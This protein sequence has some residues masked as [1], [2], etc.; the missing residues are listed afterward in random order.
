MN[1]P[2]SEQIEEGDDI[3]NMPLRNLTASTLL[4]A[5]ATLVSAQPAAAESPKPALAIAFAGYD[6]FI[7]D[8]KTLDEISG[9]TKLASLAESNIDLATQSKGLEGLD[10]ARPWGV[11]VAL[12]DDGQPIVQGFLPVTDL[13]KLVASIP[14]PGG[15][16]PD[17]NDKGVYEY[18]LG[19][20]SMFVKQKG[21]WAV[22]SDSEEN[23][24]SASE[25]AVSEFSELPKKYLLSVRG[26][27]KNVPEAA[28]DKALA[29]LRGFVELTLS[30]QPSGS[31]EQRALLNANVKQMFEKLEILGKEL[32]SLVI[33]VGLD[34]ESKSLFLDFESRAKSDTGLAKKF[35]AL[36]DAKT[37]FAGFEL[38]GAALTMLSAGVADDE[39]V[40]AA[41]ATL[42]RCKKL[43][44]KALDDN[45]AL[46]D[47]RDM[48]KKLLGDLLDVAEKTIELKKS[49]G[50][51]AIL[52]N[53]GPVMIAGARIAAGEKLES[54][55]K[56][57]VKELTAD[58]PKLSDI[59]S[60]DV[61]K[62]E[63][64][65]FHVATLPINDPE[66][67]KVLGDTVKI[68]VGISESSV[69]IGAGKD[70]IAKIKEAIDG[71]KASPG[72]AI[73]PMK[74]I[75]SGTPIAKFF[76]KKIPDDN[77]DGAGQEA[78][79]QGRRVARQVR[80]QR[81]YRHDREG[82]S[83]RRLH[84]AEGGIGRDQGPSRLDARGRRRFGRVGR[85]LEKVPSTSRRGLG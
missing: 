22:F 67:A 4:V 38:P 3:V 28:R 46:G 10:K 53:D 44:D 11:L 13:K 59:I 58:D 66:A 21:K 54:T 5:L 48:A 20:K 45:D 56:K 6:Q 75:V 39:D 36:G 9:H 24:G 69:Y 82:H 64:V 72:Q 78:I 80:R 81:P 51:M 68:A 76:A 2:L 42:D 55:I 62:Y 60:L 33:G 29:T 34:S 85:E 70:P 65:N 14:A 77:P 26:S 15:A 32:D 27:V 49:D 73:D 37:D 30:M 84:A 16:A 25:D 35:S 1:G 7:H 12:N 71:S 79:P 43:A 47:K 23:L 31:D 40:E 18:P 83:R 57:L 8:L 41:K 52:L 74:L 19:G 50:G 61:E 17:P 63:G